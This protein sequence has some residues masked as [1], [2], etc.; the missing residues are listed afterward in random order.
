MTPTGNLK[1]L[2]NALRGAENARKT[3]KS[4]KDKQEAKRACRLLKAKIQALR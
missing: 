2:E 1:R 4:H 3:A